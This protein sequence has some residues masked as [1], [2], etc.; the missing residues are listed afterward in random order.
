MS[1]RPTTDIRGVVLDAHDGMWHQFRNRLDGLGDD[2]YRWA[3]RAHFFAVAAEAMRRIVIER[4][5]HHGRLKRGGDLKRVSLA[6][7]AARIGLV[8]RV[9]P[10]AGLHEA[11]TQLAGRLAQGPTAAYGRTKRLLNASLD[12][13]LAGQLAAECECFTASTLT[14]DFRE[15][16]TAFLEKRPAAF[17]GR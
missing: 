7:D 9:V 1:E 6:E 12:N 15:G 8:N 11:T 4:V 10:A 14:E 5:R 16:V 17:T 3:N 13:G 2:E